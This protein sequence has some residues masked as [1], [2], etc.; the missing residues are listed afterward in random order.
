MITPDP[1]GL[2]FVL[3]CTVVF[4]RISRISLIVCAGGDESVLVVRQGNVV[5]G[6][7]RW[8]DKVTMALVLS[9]LGLQNS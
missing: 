1:P 4:L 8:R 6:L 7:V 3:I 2:K 5:K 9:G